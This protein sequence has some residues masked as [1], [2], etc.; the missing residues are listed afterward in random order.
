MRI[1]YPSGADAVADVAARSYGRMPDELAVRVSAV[2]GP[3]AITESGVVRA[4][5]R[6]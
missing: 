1:G 5:E 3:V 2:R 4:F 6:T